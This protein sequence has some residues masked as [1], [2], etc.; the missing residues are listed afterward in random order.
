MKRLIFFI[1]CFCVCIVSFAQEI[2]VSGKVTSSD[3]GEEM[4]GVTIKGSDKSHMAITN[5]DGVRA[6]KRNV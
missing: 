6:V 3:T 2:S 4:V 1:T 5:I